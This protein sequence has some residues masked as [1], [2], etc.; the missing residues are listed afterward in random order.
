MVMNY[1]KGRFTVYHSSSPEET[2]R[3]G[4]NFG[5]EY[6][7]PGAIITIRGELGAGKTHFVKG[8]ARALGIDER[9]LTSPTY[10]LVN[11]Y[12]CELNGKPFTLF[13]LDCYR[14]EKPEEL[15]ELGVED[16]LYPHHAATIVEWP[17]R[18]EQFI[19]EGTIEVEILT[20][21]ETEREI[22]I[23][24]LSKTSECHSERSK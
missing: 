8:I 10:A 22:I 2:I 5:R 16:Y 15:I 23:R 11:E 17:E 4:E 18:I 7:H 20:I 19:P 9:E 14:F 6:I 21:S 12:E 24:N 3:L 1:E 13:H